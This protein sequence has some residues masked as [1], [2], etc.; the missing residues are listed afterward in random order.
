M[1]PALQLLIRKKSNSKFKIDCSTLAD[2]QAVIRIVRYPSAW[3]HMSQGGN[4][5]NGEN[6][7]ALPKE[8]SFFK[9]EANKSDFTGIGK[10]IIRS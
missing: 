5:F 8:S 3:G 9:L 4:S 2:R 7:N 6:G 10:L 1:L